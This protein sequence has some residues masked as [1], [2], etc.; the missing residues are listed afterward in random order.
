MVSGVVSH[1]S[2][3]LIATVVVSPSSVDSA[4]RYWVAVGDRSCIDDVTWCCDVSVP[5][6]TAVVAVTVVSLLS[7][8]PAVK[9]VSSDVS[10][11]YLLGGRS[12]VAASGLGSSAT[13]V[14]VCVG[15][16]SPRWL[17]LKGSVGI[18]LAVVLASVEIVLSVVSSIVSTVSLATVDLAS[19]HIDVIVV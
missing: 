17:L 5:V 8:G 9:A 7:L 11:V 13:A 16:Y 18:M 15:L 12:R 6:P 4:V 14:S 2:A 1:H 10:V 19:C 3:Y